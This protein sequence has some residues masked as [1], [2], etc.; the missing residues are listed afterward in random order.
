MK[1]TRCKRCCT[2]DLPK[3]GRGAPK[4]RGRLDR[5]RKE[6]CLFVSLLLIEP[7][8]RPRQAL[9]PIIHMEI[10]PPGLICLLF[11][12]A[13]FPRETSA[14]L[15]GPFI[16]LAHRGSLTAPLAP[17]H[18]APAHEMPGWGARIKPLAGV[19]QVAG[20]RCWL[21]L[22][23]MTNIGFA[24]KFRGG[25]AHPECSS[26]LTSPHGANRPSLG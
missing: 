21:A 3:G 9:G 6:S 24:A 22:N 14:G 17:H 8:L 23:R 4:V 1:S 10:A 13:G 16:L 18:A 12:I 19:W 25:D 11:V 15:P 5:P 26:K 20:P 7:V 2:K